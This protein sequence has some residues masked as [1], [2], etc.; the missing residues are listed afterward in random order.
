MPPPHNAPDFNLCDLGPQELAKKCE[1]IEELLKSS[2][3]P[4]APLSGVIMF[5][6]MVLG[7]TVA[8]YEE[9]PRRL[10]TQCSEQF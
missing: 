5:L 2:E 4:S 6:D 3:D 9:R 10:L 8:D 1:D 7:M